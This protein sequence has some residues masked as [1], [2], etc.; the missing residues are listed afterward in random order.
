M[1]LIDL[2]A[3]KEKDVELRLLPALDMMKIKDK[4]DRGM[5][6]IKVFPSRIVSST[7]FSC[8]SRIESWVPCRF[9]A[10]QFLDSMFETRN[11]RIGIPIPSYGC[12]TT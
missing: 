3:G 6:S 5:I 10:H 11:R 1:P 2:V 12:F 7:K 4:K 8:M 9:R